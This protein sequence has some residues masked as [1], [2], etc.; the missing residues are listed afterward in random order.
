MRRIA[1]TVGAILVCCSGA[2]AQVDPDPDG[3][4]IY[5][6]EQGYTN[7]VNLEP[8]VYGP[9][10]CYLLITQASEPSGV[11]GWECRLDIEGPLFVLWMEFFGGAFG[12]PIGPDIIVGLNYG[13]PWAQAIALVDITIY[14]TEP[15][16]VVF[17]VGPTSTP[18]IPGYPAYAAGDDPGNVIPL[19]PSAGYDEFGNAL[20]CAVIN[21]ECPVKKQDM[22]WGGVKAL[23]R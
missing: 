20:P 6:D 22:T 12:T 13:L 10:F 8:G 7:C 11:S 16:Q 18:T 1:L 21:G 3:I 23:Y 2:V 9:G 4:G 5:F 14:L 15:G 19:Y 17:T